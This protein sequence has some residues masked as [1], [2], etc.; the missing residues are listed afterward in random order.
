MRINKLI[1]AGFAAAALA[2]ATLPALADTMW[3]NNYT[4]DW[5]DVNFEWYANVGRP[6][7]TEQAPY[8]TRPG[9][10]W[11]PGRY[12]NQSASQDPVWV[13][14]HFVKDDFN[15]QVAA[16]QHENVAQVNR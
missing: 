12:E 15:E 7:N 11:A 3:P 4:F 8:P 9:Y 13:P 14:G 6:L 2:S 16:L 10:I 5:P 1:S